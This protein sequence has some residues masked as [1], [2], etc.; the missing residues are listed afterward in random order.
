MRLILITL[1][2]LAAPVVAQSSPEP[3][4]PGDVD[5]SAVQPY[6]NNYRIFVKQG[7]GGAGMPYGTMAESFSVED[8]VAL[9]TV[10]VNA[11]GQTQTDSVWVVWPSLE[12]IRQYSS[13]NGMVEEISFNGLTATGTLREGGALDASFDLPLFGTGVADLLA[14]TLPMEEGA[15]LSFYTFDDEAEGYESTTLVTVGGTAEVLGRTARVITSDDGENTMTM[16]LE[17]ST[18]EM[19]Q[20]AFAPQPGITVEIRR[21]DMEEEATE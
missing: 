8:G 5:V 1:A 21:S 16:Y 2:L 20:V 14:R 3:L 10:S 13:L 6:Q 17:E 19:L 15:S 12:P 7:T 9:S 4:R 18:G 11:P